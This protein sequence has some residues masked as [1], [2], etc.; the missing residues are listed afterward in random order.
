MTTGSHTNLGNKICII[1]CSSS[2]KST[3]GTRLSNKLNIPIT[4]LDLLAHEHDTNWHRV[5]DEELIKSQNN[6][7]LTTSWI[8]EGNYSACMH[9]RFEQA[10]SVIWIDLNVFTALF[11][12]AKRCLFSNKKRPGKLPGSRKEFSFWLVKH[13]LVT[14]PKNRL[15]YRSLLK[16]FDFPIIKITSIKALKKFS[17]SL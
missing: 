6:L 8:I 13:I 15:K 16:K 12:Y 14:Y 5:T 3:L 9:E 4:H 2:G 10:T 17:D 11:F 1:G 7:L